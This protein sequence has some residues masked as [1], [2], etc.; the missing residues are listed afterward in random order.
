MMRFRLLGPL[1]VRDGDVW[2]PIG[3]P[4]WRALLAVLLIHANQIV[5]VDTLIDELWGDAV[6]AKAGNLVSI[7]VLRL[8]RLIGDADGSVLVTHSPGYLL[9][10]GDD[11]TDVQVF[12][13]M[14]REGRIALRADAF[15]DAARHLAEA[16]ALWRGAPLADVPRSGIVEAEAERLAELKLDTAELRINAELACGGHA[17]VVPELRRLLA[18]N[19]LRE[20]LWLLLMQALDGS[21]RHAEAL[22]A[23]GQARTVIA[24]ELGVDP[25]L[26]LRRLYAR[27]LSADAEE[28]AASAGPAGVIIAGEVADA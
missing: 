25:G 8:R 28:E 10:T 13:A 2:R 19:P 27:L 18:D 21:G 16:L 14:V 23:Y 24:D 17:Q 4:K 11:G 3:A 20:G 15:D 22:D 7:Y 12:E 6:P 9:K 26:E 5:S 1:E